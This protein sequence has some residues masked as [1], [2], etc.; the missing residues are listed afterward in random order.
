LGKIRPRYIKRIARKLLAEYGHLITDDFEE[1][2]RILNMIAEIRSKRVRNR[3]AGYLVRLVKL[4]R[5]EYATP[6]AEERAME[7]E[8]ETEIKRYEEEKQAESE[9]KASMEAS[10]EGEK[11]AGKESGEAEVKPQEE[12][13]GK[14]E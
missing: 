8:Y 4:G 11:A 3:V 6:T 5:E 7:M 2:K 13:S 14:D 12:E 1:N 10:G 9:S